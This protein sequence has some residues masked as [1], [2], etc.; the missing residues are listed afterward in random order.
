V[1]QK[2]CVV[3]SN[4]MTVYSCCFEPEIS[5]QAHV[6]S[7]R[8]VSAN[9]YVPSSQ[10]SLRTLEGSAAISTSLGRTTASHQI[11]AKTDVNTKLRKGKTKGKKQRPEPEANNTSD[12][13]DDSLEREAALASPVKG[14]AARKANKVSNDISYWH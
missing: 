3:F 10:A 7:H 14:I 5:A 11:A 13:N 9:E 2:E 4:K 12:D 1:A 6:T 8:T